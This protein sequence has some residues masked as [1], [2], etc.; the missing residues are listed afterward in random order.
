M[1]Q[2]LGCAIPHSAVICLDHGGARRASGGPS[3]D[4]LDPCPRCTCLRARRQSGCSAAAA[5]ALLC[6][7]DSWMWQC[8]FLAVEESACWGGARWHWCVHS[9]SIFSCLSAARTESW[10]HAPTLFRASFTTIDIDG[11]CRTC[12]CVVRT[13]SFWV[14][15]TPKGPCITGQLRRVFLNPKLSMED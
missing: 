15:L 11:G 10:H 2:L 13:F 1:A 5:P 3:G 4:A 7:A 6:W 12:W 14:S 9:I 8:S